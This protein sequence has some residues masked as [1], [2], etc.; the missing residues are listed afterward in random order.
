[1]ANQA[2]RETIIAQDD[3]A[4]AKEEPHGKQ[5]A[6]SR[7]TCKSYLFLGLV[8]VY[9]L[10]SFISDT[11]A[12][13]EALQSIEDSPIRAEFR[14]DFD[15]PVIA[16][17]AHKLSRSTLPPTGHNRS[18]ILIHVGK[19]GGSS[20][21]TNS[22]LRPGCLPLLKKGRETIS[23]DKERMEWD[24]CFLL[25]NKGQKISMFTE[26]RVFHMFDKNATEMK[27]ATTF[28][29]TLR[30]PV[31]R[32]ISAFRFSHPANCLR[33]EDYPGERVPPNRG[34]AIKNN[35]AK[36]GQPDQNKTGNNAYILFL[37]C[38]PSAAMEDLAQDVMKPWR[39]H[40][41]DTAAFHGMTEAEQSMCRDM[42]QDLL[43]GK[44]RLLVPHMR[45]NYDYYAT[46]SIRKFP[47]KEYFGIR[48]ENEWEDFVM[49]DR[50]IGG[51]GLY[52]KMHK[53]RTHGSQYYQ[54]S[55]LSKEAYQKL[56]CVMRDE[57]QVYF[58]FFDAAKN[59]NENDKE[60][61][62][63]TIRDRCGI[64]ETSSWET[65]RAMCKTG[66]LQPLS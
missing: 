49:V 45:Y 44:L 13:L 39:T 57:F 34:C 2:C 62:E 36:W 7:S 18:I 30:N 15:A 4:V 63:Q 48:T 35:D 25:Y 26:K 59:L 22:F 29:V 54:P 38:Y 64:P 33:S 41:N 46:H 12:V 5:S 32:L 43:V 23:S 55:P 50:M 61:K 14:A 52:E 66:V 37:K 65:W 28:L 6:T 42:A 9:A 60:E 47:R 16:T 53:P 56:C 58:E 51:S 3:V 17:G 19:A 8:I 21:R 24:N 27:H 20:L 10:R 1:M 40:V 31:D 11:R